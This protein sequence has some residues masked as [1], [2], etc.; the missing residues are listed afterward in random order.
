[1]GGQTITQ[2][3]RR[4]IARAI[5]GGRTLYRIAKDSGVDYSALWHFTKNGKTLTLPKAEKLMK[6]FGLTVTRAKPA[7]PRAGK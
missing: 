2:V 7:R 6:Y 5:R 3:L 4:E 1:M